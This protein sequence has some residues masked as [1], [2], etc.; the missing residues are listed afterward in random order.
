MTS[1]KYRTTKYRT[2]RHGILIVRPRSTT[3][4]AGAILVTVQKKATA[5]STDPDYEMRGLLIDTTGQPFPTRQRP[6]G[7][8]PGFLSCQHHGIQTETPKICYGRDINNNGDLLGV[9]SDGTQ[10][11]AFIYN[12]GLYDGVALRSLMSCRSQLAQR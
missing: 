12:T 6:G 7:Q 3:R 9:F 11:G 8:P 10:Y 4:V 1:L 2:I 5:D